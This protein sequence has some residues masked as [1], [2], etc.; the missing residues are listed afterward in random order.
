MTAPFAAAARVAAA[1]VDR[2]FGDTFAYHPMA[3]GADVNSRPAPD[4]D[5]AIVTGLRLIFSAQGARAASGPTASPAM[6]VEKPGHASDRPFVALD[7]SLLPYAPCK[8]DRLL[9]GNGDLF[10]VA[11]VVPS[12]PGF[13]RLDLNQIARNA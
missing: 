9:A 12:T 13:A 8:G 2:T 10:R 11:E 3:T 6:R 7:L 4:P 1:I 5:R